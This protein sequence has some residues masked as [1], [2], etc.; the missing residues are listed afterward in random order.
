LSEDEILAER[1]RV[2][3][4]RV[5]ELEDQVKGYV[6]NGIRA[7]LAGAGYLFWVAAHNIPAFEVFFK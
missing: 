5:A 6:R 4:E 7:I 3:Q 1:L 2:L